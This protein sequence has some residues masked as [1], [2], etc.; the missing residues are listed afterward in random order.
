VGVIETLYKKQQ[1]E[2]ADIVLGKALNDPATPQADK[3]QLHILEGMLRMESFQEPQARKAF[4]EALSMDREAVLPEFAPPATRSLFLD[5]KATLPLTTTPP[6]VKPPTEATGPKPKPPRPE[7]TPGSEDYL[8]YIPI[9]AGGVAVLAGGGFVVASRV[10]DGSL[11]SGSAQITTAEGL[12][13]T[14]AT[15]QTYQT[16]GY[17]LVGVGGAVLLG[18]LVWKFAPDVAPLLSVNVAPTNQGFA[19]V[20]SGSLP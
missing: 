2:A 4:T 6:P 20:I 15:G 16:T 19:A 17:V 18:G 1:Y 3:V 5:V 9:G 8:P 12:R 11:R 7:R 14:V 13:S 10:V